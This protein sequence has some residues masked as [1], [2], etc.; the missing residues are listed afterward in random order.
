MKSLFDFKV[1]SV[2]SL[3][4]SSEEGP[5]VN[6]VTN[7]QRFEVSANNADESVQMFA[8]DVKM[9]NSF[10][11]IETISLT[12]DGVKRAQCNET[13]L[14]INTPEPRF[15]SAPMPRCQFHY[16]RKR[17]FLFKSHVTF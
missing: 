8:K 5:T 16:H 3:D 11:N 4:S 2:Y 12:I 13:G 14:S 17:A 9:R 10:Q 6:D 7:L 15:Y 1:F